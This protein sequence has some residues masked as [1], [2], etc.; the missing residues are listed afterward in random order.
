MDPND[1]FKS[2]T[3]QRSVTQ[4]DERDLLALRIRLTREIEPRAGPHAV[5]QPF[6]YLSE[7]ELREVREA[8]TKKDLATVRNWCD[9]ARSRYPT[10]DP[11]QPN[12]TDAA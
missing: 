1:S 7:D 11:G 2:L 3:K 10:S 4:A 6:L 5:L 12:D 9:I 8:W